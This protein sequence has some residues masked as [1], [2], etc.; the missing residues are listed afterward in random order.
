MSLISLIIRSQSQLYQFV[1]SNII[2]AKQISTSLLDCIA[3]SLESIR[4]NTRKQL[5]TAMSQTFMQ[6]GMQVIR[7]ITISVDEI[8]SFLINNKF[9]Q[10]SI[11]MRSLIVCFSQ[12]SYR[13][14]LAAMS[15]ANP[16][17]I[18]KIDT[19][20][21]SRIFITP[22]HG[23]TDNMSRHT[24]HLSLL[25]LRSYRRMVLKPLRI[26]ADS[27]STSGCLH[28][29]KF[30]KTFPGSFQSKRITINLNKT[31]DKIN[32]TLLLLDPCNAISVEIRK[33]ASA[34]IL[35][36]KIDDMSL[37]LI[38]CIFLSFQEPG[39]NLLNGSTIHTF[40]FPGHFY[41]FSIPLHQFGIESIGRWC[42]VFAILQSG[43]KS[44]HLILGNVFIE[45]AGRSGYQINT[46]SLI[47]TLRKNFLIKNN[48]HQFIQQ[49]FFGLTSFQRQFCLRH[50][51]NSLIEEMF[52]KT[53]FEFFTTIMVV[54]A[55]GE[56]DSLEV[57]LESL[58]VI[59]CS[60]SIVML[61]DSL[62]SL[63][64]TKIVL[65]LLVEGNITAHQGS[66]CQAINIY[67]LRKCQILKTI[68]AIAQHLQVGK[69]LIC[70]LKMFVRI[71][72]HSVYLFIMMQK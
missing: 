42:Q 72:H 24:F 34:I 63:T 9:I 1:I 40:F 25:E 67:L 36:Q 52:G 30:N 17:S 22:Q 68:Q 2:Q 49:V 12:I 16:V 38:F 54:D 41:D 48:G 19:D 69:T 11:A 21:R 60:I 44:F 56:P 31:I 5:T 14:T 39:S 37:L 4:V 51:R 8:K 50:H 65:S 18:R 70:E 13:H 29:F 6:V 33:V 7:H 26:L 35:D 58:E 66:L 47:H 55:A 3:I 32:H 23:S 45:I 61:I 59:R 64:D 57:N 53:R 15:L 27:L 20:G 43:I 62:Q 46:I 71:A 10:E 28:I